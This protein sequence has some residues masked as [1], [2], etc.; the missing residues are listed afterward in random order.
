MITIGGRA[1][2]VGV[3]VT[4]AFAAGGLLV[5]A[6][7]TVEDTD[8]SPGTPRAEAAAAELPATT[9]ND[10][11]DQA[12]A[13]GGATG[14]AR[15]STTTPATAAPARIGPDWHRLTP[16]TR[17]RVTR[18]YSVEGQLALDVE[19]AQDAGADPL[20]ASTVAATV[21]KTGGGTLTC[22]P[23]QADMQRLGPPRTTVPPGGTAAVVLRCWDDPPAD[24]TLTLRA[25][26]SPP[27]TVTGPVTTG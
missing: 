3:A 8:D 25:Y 7:P 26:G 27:L 24:L 13:V 10:V 12:P 6:G 23:W 18:A 5:T 4:A 20:I 9:G 21:P 15:P 14:T 2:R 16:T 17:V 1:V 19:Y 11:V 22:Q